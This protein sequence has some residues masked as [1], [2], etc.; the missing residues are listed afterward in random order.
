MTC[1]AALPGL[2]EKIAESA[3]LQLCMSGR[4]IAFCCLHA[5]V[6]AVHLQVFALGADL[7]GVVVPA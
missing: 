7:E 4:A 3:L 1:C 5:A 6:V 2:R